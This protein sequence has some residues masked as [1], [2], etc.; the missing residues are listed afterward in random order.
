MTQPNPDSFEA[1]E[2]EPVLA[3]VTLVL[4]GAR[5]GKSGYAESLIEAACRSDPYGIYLATAE[6]GDAEMAARIRRHK[7]RRGT[8]W[9][10]IEEP[11]ELASALA[12]HAAPGRPI[13]VDCLTLWLNN[14]TGA[15]REPVAETR[16]LTDALPDLPGPVVFVSNEV[17]LGIVPENRIA[18]AFRDH[19]GRLHQAVAVHAQRVVF[20]TAGLPQTLKG[21]I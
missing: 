10:T 2:P 5:S 14:L 19:A 12:T 1:V 18:R 4:G 8:G 3:P 20:M 13:L 9:I 11:L 21:E 16:S 15:G 6:P 17:G 7:A